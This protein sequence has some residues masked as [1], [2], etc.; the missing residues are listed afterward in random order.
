MIGETSE[1]DKLS[2]PFLEKLPG[3]EEAAAAGAEQDDD[4][5]EDDSDDG[6]DGAEHGGPALHLPLVEHHAARA[7][8]LADDPRVVAPEPAGEWRELQ[9]VVLTVE[10]P[11]NPVAVVAVPAQEPINLSP[12]VVVVPAVATVAP[13]VPTEGTEPARELAQ[14]VCAVRRRTEDRRLLQLRFCARFLLVA[15]ATVAT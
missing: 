15:A 5:D 13:A 9:L 2:Y 12:A 14:L 10:L 11:V 8:A 7:G 4:A 1:C 3:G 6:A